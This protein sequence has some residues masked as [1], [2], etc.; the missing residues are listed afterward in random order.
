M[1][2]SLPSL[3]SD[4]RAGREE[5]AEQRGYLIVEAPP[6]E[7]LPPKVRL[8]D[9]VDGTVTEPLEEYM[10]Q[11]LLRQVVLRCSVC[12][13]GYARANQVSIHARQAMEI[14]EQHRGARFVMDIVREGVAL[15]RCTGCDSHFEQRSPEL[16]AHIPRLV[17]RGR[18]HTEVREV[19]Q[20]RYSRALSGLSPH[21]E[22]NIGTEVLALQQRSASAG[23][24]GVTAVRRRHRRHHKG[25]GSAT[26]PEDSNSG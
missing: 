4:T 13:K 12:H 9:L 8:R 3:R 10:A 14:G 26:E 2:Q 24:N 18:A 11:H 6:D 20:R 23:V 19:V 7:S 16:K 21:G 1:T 17:E 15:M 5:L 22:P 25:K